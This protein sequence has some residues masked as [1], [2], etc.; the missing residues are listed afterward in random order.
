MFEEMLKNA[1]S[2][3]KG[4]RMSRSPICVIYFAHMIS[5]Y[6]HQRRGAYGANV[7]TYS[8]DFAARQAETR[9][10]QEENARKQHE[11]R[12]EYLK[13]VAELGMFSVSLL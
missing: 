3:E 12:Q 5:G 10:K 6:F 13:R 2:R 4:R 8:G 11:A 7:Y 1:Y 9:R